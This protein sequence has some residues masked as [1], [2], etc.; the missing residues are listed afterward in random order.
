VIVNSRSGDAKERWLEIGTSWFQHPEDWSAIPVASGPESWQRIDVEVDLN[1]RE[2]EPDKP[3]R[4]VDIV[5]PTQAIDVVATKTIKISNVVLE[6]SSI[7]FS[8]DEIGQPVL[9]R[10]SYFPNWKIS[11]A[12]GPYRVA[13]NLMVVVPT[14]NEVRLNY[15]YTKFELFAY[16]LTAA[17]IAIVIMRWRRK[18]NLGAETI[19]ASIN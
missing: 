17:G 19:E 11:G 12:E 13:P 8:V 10:M 5:K 14:Q 15:G 6:D 3:N 16:L 4:R 18:T 1:R 2:G 7:S 9:V